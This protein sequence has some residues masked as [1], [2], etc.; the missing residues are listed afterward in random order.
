MFA[1][2]SSIKKGA[3]ANPITDEATIVTTG[4]EESANDI[5]KMFSYFAGQFF[6]KEEEKKVKEGH[7][8]KD[9]TIIIAAEKAKRYDWGSTVQPE[10]FAKIQK[11]Q[12]AEKQKHLATFL[13][14]FPKDLAKLGQDLAEKLPLIQKLFAAWQICRQEISRITGTNYKIVSCKNKKHHPPQG[15]RFA[16][17]PSLNELQKIFSGWIQLGNEI[18]S[19]FALS[20]DEETTIDIKYEASK[21]AQAKLTAIYDRIGSLIKIIR[22]ETDVMIRE[23]RTLERNPKIF[24]QPCVNGAKCQKEGCTYAPI[25]ELMRPEGFAPKDHSLAACLYGNKCLSMAE[26]GKCTHLHK[27]QKSFDKKES[28]KE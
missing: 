16:H 25:P 15:C 2:L 3:A 14:T 4:A 6:E 7:M 8:D 24:S 26:H 5:A 21:E 20:Q 10:A 22:L 28:K 9:G 17:S 13:E 1:P 27:Q 12:E 18:H 19:A 11:E 23:L